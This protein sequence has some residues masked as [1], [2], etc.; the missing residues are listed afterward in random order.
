SIIEGSSGQKGP[1][2]RCVML[3]PLQ[4]VNQ[5]CQPN[6]Q[7]WSVVNSYTYMLWSIMEIKEGES[8]TVQYRKDSAYFVG[9][10]TCASC[11]P[12]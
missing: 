8:I 10:H 7:I 2:G 1:L 4:F 3:G 11:H 6:G 9:K 12:E 5:D